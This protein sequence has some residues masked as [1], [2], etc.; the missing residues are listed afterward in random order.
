LL[1]RTKTKQSESQVAKI[2]SETNCMPLLTPRQADIVALARDN[3][4]LDVDGLAS[5]FGVTPQTIRKDLNELCDQG[6]LQRY[7]GGAMLPSGV[8]NLAYESRRQLATDAKRRIGLKAAELI[9]NDCSLLINIG[10]TTE[11]VATALRSHKGLMVITNN[12]NVV[13]ILQG[14][15]EIEV[16][17]AGG[18]LRH[19]DGGIVG[20]PAVDFLRQFKVD[21]A[22]IG[23]SAI[24]EDGS[25][26]DY[27]YRE[28]EVSRKIVE[29]SRHA[30]LVA[31]SLKYGRSAP[32]RI[33]HIS[34][35]DRF[36]TDA[37]PSERLQRIC[38]ENHVAVD[39]AFEKAGEVAVGAR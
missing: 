39:I 24:D 3:G 6:V 18:V 31:D 28:V 38:A 16:I 7:H 34:D 10:T 29:S 14:Y 2:A 19:A 4:R 30:I 13:N 23:T 9:P 22:I 11:Q 15:T 26:L 32:V 12:M 37:A 21:Y 33:G 27:D 25:L 36:V 20:E 17:V 5:R 1:Q 8:A 35:I